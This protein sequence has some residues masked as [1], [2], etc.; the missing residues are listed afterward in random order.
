MG[1]NLVWKHFFSSDYFYFFPAMLVCTTWMLLPIPEIAKVGLF[2]WSL[3]LFTAGAAHA[4]HKGQ[5]TL[6]QLIYRR[7]PVQ[8]VMILFYTV[9]G[10]SVSHF[11]H[12]ALDK[13][14]H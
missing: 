4:L 3:P 6:L 5:D 9:G 13:G 2:L 11:A 10:A 12:I 8:G 14:S 1:R 7:C